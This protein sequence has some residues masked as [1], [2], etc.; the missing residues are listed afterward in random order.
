M[1]LSKK[2]NGYLI[3]LLIYFIFTSEHP[4]SIIIITPMNPV[5]CR[6]RHSTKGVR[7]LALETSGL[8]LETFSLEKITLS[9]LLTIPRGFEN[10]IVFIACNN[11]N[12]I[13]RQ[14]QIGAKT[15]N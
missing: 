4:P 15:N 1:F 8:D 2:N 5:R 13:F 11:K 6:W 12:S 14:L 7:K 9:A 10:T 3:A